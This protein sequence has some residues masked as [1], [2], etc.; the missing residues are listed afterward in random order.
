[1]GPI[2]SVNFE[3]YQ[4]VVSSGPPSF[5]VYATVETGIDSD[6]VEIPDTFG[7]GQIQVSCRLRNRIL[8]LG[9]FEMTAFPGEPGF[10]Y[11]LLD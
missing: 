11:I 3:G 7:P 5:T 10:S 6:S 2:R 9:R 8:G 4:W 1:M